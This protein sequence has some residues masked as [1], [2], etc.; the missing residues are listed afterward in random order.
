[1]AALEP[2]RSDVHR[3]A[4][5]RAR[6]RVRESRT[7]LPAA[8]HLSQNRAR[9]IARADRGNARRPDARHRFLVQEDGLRVGAEQRMGTHGTIRTGMGG[10]SYAPWRETSYP[11]EVAQ[12][13]EL[14]YASRQVT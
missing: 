6:D 11:A 14:E 2:A 12:R 7:R 4:G 1:R 3:R 10:W 5:R 9:R 13:A 8:S